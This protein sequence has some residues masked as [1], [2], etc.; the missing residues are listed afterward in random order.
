MEQLGGQDPRD[1]SVHFYQSRGSGEGSVGKKPQWKDR[2]NIKPEIIKARIT[3]HGRRI[4]G[5]TNVE[6]STEITTSNMIQK[7]KKKE[8]KVRNAGAD[9]RSLVVEL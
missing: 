6:M 7:G 8:A 2:G 9:G 3:A 4:I 5:F 1:T